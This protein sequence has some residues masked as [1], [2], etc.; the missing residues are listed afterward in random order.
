MGQSMR[1]NTNA[2]GRGRDLPG[3]QRHR[4]S[5][6]DATVESDFYVAELDDGRQTDFVEVMLSE[7]EAR[8]AGAFRAILDRGEWPPSSDTRAGIAA[9]AALQ[10]CGVLPSGGRARASRTTGSS[11]R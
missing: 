11:C 3:D 2:L 5:V 10:I 4:V 1:T 8:T 6:N 9:W 7:I